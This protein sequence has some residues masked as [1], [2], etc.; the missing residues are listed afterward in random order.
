VVQVEVADMVLVLERDLV[1]HLLYHLHK[2]VLVVL[3]H[4]VTQLLVQEEV[5]AEQE[6]PAKLHTTHQHIVLPAMVE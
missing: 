2:V 6:P 5:E 4:L 3:D 1:I